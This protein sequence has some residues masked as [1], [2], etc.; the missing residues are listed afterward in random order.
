MVE[1][2]VILLNDKSW[3]VKKSSTRGRGLFAKEAMEAG[4]IIGD[5]LGKVM[6][7]ATDD[8]SEKDGLYL[9]YYSDKASI[10][11]SDLKK[12]GVHFLNH[13]C[14]PNCWMYIYRGHTLFFT[15]RHIFAGEEFT[16]SYQLSPKDKLCNPCM[17][18]C[19][20]GDVNCRGTMHLAE[21]EYKDWNKFSE[22]QAKETKKAA[23][24]YGK[25]LAPLAAYPKNIRDNE[26]Y[27]LTGFGNI[28]SLILDD[29]KI[30]S[31]K[32]IRKMIRTT[33]K[34]I[35]MPRQKVRILGTVG[36]EII[37]VRL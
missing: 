13:A 7:T 20:C 4:V 3:E 32:K 1:Y 33:G 25:N 28:P 23:I 18:V 22:N 8:I 12:P 31:I 24:R 6:R 29:K 16:I 2:L 15:L 9:M 11:P 27:R 34:T 21:D 26:I 17:H 10:L 30:P 5:Y 35:I 19:L 37:S 14:N 36:A